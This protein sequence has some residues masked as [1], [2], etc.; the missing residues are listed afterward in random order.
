M[1]LSVR[2]WLAPLAVTALGLLG[3]CSSSGDSPLSPRLTPAGPSR[4]LGA[5]SSVV[6]SQVYGGGGNQGATLKNDFIELYNPGPTDVVVT[7]WSVQYASASG[8]SWQV[9]PLTGTIPAGHYYLVQEAAGTGGVPFSI[10]ADVTTGTIPMSATGGKV[11]LV[12][13]T[14]ALSGSCPTGL[15]DFVGFGGANCFEG[16]GPTPAPNNTNAVLRNANA[17][18]TNDNAAD[19][20]TG[21]P[22]PRNT[23][24][25][26]SGS[27][28]QTTVASVA[29][30]PSNPTIFVGGTQT[31]TASASDAD[32]QP[33]AG[34]AFTW[35]SNNTSV[36]TV[37]ATGKVT[38]VAL[39]TA[40]ITATSPNNV[41]GSTTVTVGNAPP[42]VASNVRVSEFHYDNVGTDA[43]EQIEVEGDVGGTVNGWSLVLY[44]G[45]PGS[46]TLGQSYATIAMTG[47]FA[48][49]A[50]GGTRGVLVFDT[51]GLQNGDADGFALVNASGQV[52]E[53]L[54]YEG[55][56]QATN[57]PAAGMTSTD[58]GVSEANAPAI[59]R[60]LQRAGNG[61]WYGPFP[62]TFGQC[63]PATP[64]APQ[65]GISFSGRL[66]SDPALPIGFQDQV[67]ATLRDANT[68]ATVPTTFTWTSETPS[69]MTVDDRGVVTALALGTGI[70]RATAADGTTSTLSLPTE[71]PVFGDASLYKNPLA[72]GVPTDNSPADEFR[73][74]RDQYVLSYNKTTH[75]PNWVAEHLTKANR[76]DLPG[77]RC[78]CFAVD[79][80]V[81]DGSDPGITTADY[82]GSG[83]DRGHMVRSNDRELAHGDQAT[84]YYT[85][86][87]VPQWANLNQGRWA[88][89]E[90]YLQT[91]EEGP[92]N[93]E[94][95]IFAGPRGNA[96]TIANGRIVVPVATWKVAVVLPAGMSPS[97]IT[98]TSD[99]LDII[100]VDMPNVQNLPRDGNWQA[101]R[102]S[103]DSVEKATGY[104]LLSALPSGVEEVVESGD[105]APTARI[106]GAGTAGGDE[107]QT[108]SFS[109]ST[110]SDPDVGGSLDDV[111]SYAWAVDGATVGIGPSLSHTFADDGAH[112]LRLIVADKFGAADTAITSVT[113]ANV[114]PAVA[115]LPNATLLRGESYQAAGS[116]TDPGADTWTA[117][118]NYG[119]GAGPL[120]LSG[121]T[122]QLSHGYA[123]AGSYTV[124]VTVRDD[125]GGE[126]ART[127]QVTV[128]SAG[129]G[130]QALTEM[131]VAFQAAGKLASTEAQPLS[132][133]LSAAGRSLAADRPSSVN[134]IG[135]FINQVE[136]LQLSGRLSA[137]DAG[138]LI[139]YAR[140]ILASIG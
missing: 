23:S 106:S 37:D 57:G 118:V 77:Y 3:G 38:G 137:A 30:T 100:A 113:V 48:A 18:D 131:V 130:V 127:A 105:R 24:V 82:T 47:S 61:T 41:S 36:A 53:F 107:G 138:T 6:I 108:L 133:T 11:A 34:V 27:G 115:A 12:N 49:C 129:D 60:S 65:T 75:T 31:L 125:E 79:P 96:G 121:K 116:F 68:G 94:V 9:T 120:A 64:P 4:G 135:A 128:L 2:R 20:T 97:S 33:I 28:S 124:T 109:A 32:G 59:G 91:V 72:F 76:G 67:F 15:I 102:V 71:T 140:R 29:V 25:A 139:T 21:A 1:H 112:Q 85:T 22:N 46:A 73:V 78:D 86:N 16:T 122:F 70:I 66:S 14:S 103:V 10:T 93:P 92:G 132:A 126:G 87:I 19:F 110:S 56:F 63:N 88:D 62:S 45:T 80:K 134:Q 26:G 90:S 50:A 13:S 5:A 101:H 117:T 119:A 54:S 84:T 8:T 123:T 89:L 114:A 74:T 136:A 42:P 39:G 81:V 95:Y 83:F 99:I 52:V 17:T 69:I 44:S 51:P 58:V 40:T 104:D 7:G 35:A 55:T 43:G 111:L 98:K